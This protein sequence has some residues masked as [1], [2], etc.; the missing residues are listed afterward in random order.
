ML[1]RRDVGK[2]V[3]FDSSLHA[4]FVEATLPSDESTTRNRGE[5]IVGSVWSELDDA[6]MLVN[7]S[8]RDAHRQ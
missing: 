5:L 1:V 3:H 8:A 6:A 4:S 2:A 7:A